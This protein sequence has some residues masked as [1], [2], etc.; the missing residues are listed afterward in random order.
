M[1]KAVIPDIKQWT[2]V[3]PRST[4]HFLRFPDNYQVPEILRDHFFYICLFLNMNS[5]A[6]NDIYF[7]GRYDMKGPP[8]PKYAVYNLK[9]LDC[10]QNIK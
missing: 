1:L 10:C 9:Y 6:I 3:R 4:P 7:L 8:P 2:W 5:T